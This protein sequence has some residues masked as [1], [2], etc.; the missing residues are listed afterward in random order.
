MACSEA[1]SQFN[2]WRYAV[3]HIANLIIGERVKGR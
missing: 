2:H 3:K 1:Y